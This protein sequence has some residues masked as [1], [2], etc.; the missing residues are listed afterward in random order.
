MGGSAEIPS[1]SII[2]HGDSSNHSQEDT[3]CFDPITSVAQIKCPGAPEYETFIRRYL[4]IS[5]PFKIT[6]RKFAVVTYSLS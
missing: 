5:D 6:P 1:R 3:A 2:H 4:V